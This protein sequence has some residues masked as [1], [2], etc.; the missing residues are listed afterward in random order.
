MRRITIAAALVIV[1]AVAQTQASVQAQSQTNLNVQARGP[2]SETRLSAESQ[3]KVDA[4][5]RAAR[6]RK[7]PEQTIRNRVAEG[8]AKGASES[9]I[10]TAS[11]RTL[12][13]LQ[14]SF[15]AMVRGG[16]ATPSDVEVTRGSQLLA[17]GYTG[18]N[19]EAVAR[20]S[21]P[22][23]S[24]VVAFETLTLLQAQGVPTARALAQIENRLAAR[25]SDI[26]LR[27]LAVNTSAAAG[28]TGAGSVGA[29]R[30]AGMVNAAGSAATGAGAAAG[31]VGHAT[32]G[33]SAGVAGQVTG[34]VSGALGKP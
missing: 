8:R 13:D 27:G 9:Q 12:V 22:D 20:K 28:V 14:T 15:D 19:I 30:G 25:A 11:G 26:E 33:T 34:A 23:R 24:L 29:G 2:R 1:P 21:P 32:T 4:N 16:H 10:V 17:R 5:I 18:A 6:E 3:S 7:L 31:G